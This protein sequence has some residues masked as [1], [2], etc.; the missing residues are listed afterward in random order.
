MITPREL[1]IAEVVFRWTVRA[2]I[3]TW[4]LMPGLSPESIEAAICSDP[5]LAERI[6]AKLEEK[7]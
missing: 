1:E 2:V 7:F 4:A 3:A 6:K 5:A